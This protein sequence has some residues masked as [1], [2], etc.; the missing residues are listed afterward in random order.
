MKRKRI[1]KITAVVSL[2]M[3]LLIVFSSVAFA[4]KTEPDSTV[5]S[6]TITKRYGVLEGEAIQLSATI[7]PENAILKSLEWSSSNPDVISCTEDGVIKGIKAGGYAEITCKAKVGS[8][9][10]KIRIY[11]VEPLESPTKS[12]MCNAF[13]FI[14]SRPQSSFIATVHLNFNLFFKI[15]SP[16]FEYFVAFGIFPVPNALS[17]GTVSVVGKYDNYAYIRFSGYGITDGFV[18]HSALS[19]TIN[20]FLYLSDKNIDIWAN[21]IAYETKKLTTTYNGEVEWNVSNE[22]LV[23]YTPSTGYI[24]A[25]EPG[26]TVTITAEADGMSEKCYVHLLYRWPQSWIAKTNKD[27][28]LYSKNGSEYIKY[29]DLPKNSEVTV[30]GDDGTDSGWAYAQVG[31]NYQGY[32]KISDVS[33]KGT[34]SQYR[35]L[36]WIWPVETP[37]N[38]NK[39]NFI[40]SPYGERDADPTMHKGFDITTG[41]PGEIAGYN[42]VAA[43]NGKVIYKDYTVSTGHCVGIQSDKTDPISG[44]KM[45]AFYMHLIDSAIVYRGDSVSAGEILGYVGNTGNSGGYHLH[46]EVNNKNASIDDGSTARDYYAHLINPLFFFTDYTNN[47]VIGVESDK[48]KD[49]NE[50]KIIID[51]TCSTVVS[52]FGAYWYG[53][54]S[55]EE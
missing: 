40:S 30:M 20:G 11:C 41:V 15:L 1:S 4:V 42:V 28:F 10:D 24:V 36:A 27:T 39:A 45:V 6:V 33:T 7:S 19:K 48:R 35:N 14:Y 51:K 9:K 38:K 16:I 43:F 3:C 46:F 55:E 52:Y 53:D 37:K 22:K 2:L 32:I 13:T 50:N 18:K 34:I 29:K 25:Y 31:D 12:T 44:E 5:D 47:Y 23:K 26:H 8:A 17:M 21:G 49:G 54:D